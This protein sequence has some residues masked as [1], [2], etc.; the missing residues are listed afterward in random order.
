ML[1]WL[2]TANLVIFEGFLQNEAQIHSEWP[3]SCDS[4]LFSLIAS[5]ASH[6]IRNLRNFHSGGGVHLPEL[7]G[8]IDLR[9]NFFIPGGGVHLPEQ[10][11]HI[12]VSS[13]FFIPGGGGTSANSNL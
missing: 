5:K 2:K 6:L 11:S 4:Q 3:I 1:D 7:K 13:N 10:K 8:H 12:D 9:S